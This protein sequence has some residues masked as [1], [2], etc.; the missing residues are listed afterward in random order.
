MKVDFVNKK[1]IMCKG[2]S[3]PGFGDISDFK[4]THKPNLTLVISRKHTNQTQA[5][6]Q[7]EFMEPN[8]F[9]LEQV[10]FLRYR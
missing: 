5:E 10:T 1:S 9:S 8:E 6:G 4:K 3:W 7:I 2:N